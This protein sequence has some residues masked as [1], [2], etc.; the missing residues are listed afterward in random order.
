MIGINELRSSW[1]MGVAPPHRYGAERRTRTFT[2]FAVVLVVVGWQPANAD[3]SLCVPLRKFVDSVKPHESK[4]ITFRT[5]WG[6]GFKDSDEPSLAE[7][8]CQHDGYDP[9]K[10]V[11]ADFITNGSTEFPGANASS[12]ITCLSRVTRFAPH[13]SV[14]VIAVSFSY[15]T[16]NRG[17]LVEIRLAEDETVGGMVLTITAEGY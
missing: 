9:A 13:L 14:H 4:T 17:S 1:R 8:R 3:D 2:T 6:T 7:K 5:S 10:L 11:C 15:G 12:A 16:D